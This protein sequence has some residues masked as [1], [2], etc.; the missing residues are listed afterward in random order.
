M[1]MA[2]VAHYKLGGF[3]PLGAIF[4]A[5]V[6]VGQIRSGGK[7]ATAPAVPLSQPQQLTK[8]NS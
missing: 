7:R 5:S 4:K 3:I 1:G 8:I 2:A 6:K